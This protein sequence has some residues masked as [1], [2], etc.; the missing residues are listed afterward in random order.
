M[1]VMMRII[2]SKKVILMLVPIL[3]N[4]LAA[5]GGFAVPTDTVMLLVDGAFGMLVG[6]QGMIDFKWGSRSDG[7]LGG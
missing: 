6:I 7:S 4:A 3:A 1:Q 2:G 5:V